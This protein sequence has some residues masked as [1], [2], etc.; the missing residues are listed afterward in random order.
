MGGAYGKGKPRSSVVITRYNESK[1][2]LQHNMPATFQIE[3]LEVTDI[4]EYESIRDVF[5]PLL[6]SSNP[7]IREYGKEALEAVT[8][9]QVGTYGRTN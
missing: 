3:P 8:F 2:N 1:E 9:K 5:L 6:G 7:K 4:D